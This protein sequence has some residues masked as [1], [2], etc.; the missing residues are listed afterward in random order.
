MSNCQ[1]RKKKVSFSLEC[2]LVKGKNDKCIKAY[3]EKESER[4]ERTN[5]SVD[6]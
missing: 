5:G 3:G 4:R 1:S 6:L 2:S